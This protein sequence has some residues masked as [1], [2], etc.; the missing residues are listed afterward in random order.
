MKP[1][2]IF[3]LFAVYAGIIAVTFLLLIAGLLGKAE[4][5]VLCNTYKNIV[6]ITE[7]YSET[8]QFQ[9]LLKLPTAI[10]E[11]WVAAEGDRTF[12]VLII[13]TNGTAC[14]VAVGEKWRKTDE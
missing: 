9:G 13:Y 4:A 7:S 8:R 6:K 11:I 5:Q 3:K 14:V 1:K 12:T 10:L 2:T